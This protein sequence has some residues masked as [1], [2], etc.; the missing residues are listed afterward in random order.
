VTTPAALPLLGAIEVQSS[1]VETPELAA[2]RKQ[3]QTAARYGIWRG[4]CPV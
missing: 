2:A 4:R 3:A 1:A